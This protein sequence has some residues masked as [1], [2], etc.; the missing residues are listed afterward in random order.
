MQSHTFKYSTPHVDLAISVC[1]IRT[2]IKPLQIALNFVFQAKISKTNLMKCHGNR[3]DEIVSSIWKPWELT[4]SQSTTK[5]EASRY[6]YF[7][8][9]AQKLTK[10]N[11]P[12]VPPL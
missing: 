11:L 10:T 1:F 8:S 9:I 4:Y 2:S 5:H 6:P 12:T 3:N 7:P